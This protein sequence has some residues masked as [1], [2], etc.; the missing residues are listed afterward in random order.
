M[1]KIISTFVLGLFVFKAFSQNPTTL[2]PYTYDTRVITTGVPFLMIASDARAGGMGEMGVATS[3]DAYSQQWNPSKYGFIEKQMGVGVSYTPY[4]SSLVNDIA[5]MNLTFYNRIS[6]HSA[7]AFGLKYFSLGDI[8]F[9]EQ[10]G[11]DIVSQG[12]ERPNELAIDASY[13][14]RLTDRYSMGVTGR[15]LSSNLKIPSEGID[16]RA[17]NSFAVDVSGYFQTEEI[18]YDNYDGRWRAGFAVANIGPPIKYDESLSDDYDSFLP[19]NLKLGAGFDFIFDSYSRLSVAAEFNKLLVPT[20][21]IRGNEYEYVDNNDNGVYDEDTDDLGDVVESD[22]VI[23]GMD[24]DVSF[25]SGMFQSF[26]DAPGG[27]K[28]ELKEVTWALGAE[29]TYMDA[30]ALRAGYFNESQD[31]GARKFFTIGAGF[32][33]N[34]IKVDLSYLFSASKVRN[35]LENTLRFSLTLNFGD[36][37]DEY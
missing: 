25:V 14:L 35:P 17:A 26:H 23:S 33:Y 37:Y 3:P 6:E 34:V 36:E 29:Y 1:K 13:I 16:A 20:P 18:A 15:F 5:L 24:D 27:M 10:V 8:E 11:N 19:T 22:V 7:W 30:F 21:P 12:V 9:T 2:I 28:E 31:K 32:T 4:L